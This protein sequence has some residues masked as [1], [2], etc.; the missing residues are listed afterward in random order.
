M[1]KLH[2]LKSYPS[3]F[4]AVLDGRKT[5]EVR[6]NDRD[7]HV[8]DTLLLKEYNPIYDIYTGRAIK[9]KVT[10][11]LFGPSFGVKKDYVAMAIKVQ[12]ELP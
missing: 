11:I 5:F 9:C 4:N 12:K 10:Y 2:V 8:N 1:S 6:K 3:F 7:Y